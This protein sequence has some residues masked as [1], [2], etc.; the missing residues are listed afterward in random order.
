[1]CKNSDSGIIESV[2]NAGYNQHSPY[3]SNVRIV[4]KSN[5]TD[6]LFLIPSKIMEAKSWML[7]IF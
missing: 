7:K 1:M 4:A 3:V 5:Q 2:K 6:V